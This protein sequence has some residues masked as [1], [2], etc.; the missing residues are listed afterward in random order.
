MATRKSLLQEM[1]SYIP[2]RGKEDVIQSRAD[3]ILTSAINLLEEIHLSFP[4]EEAIALE[5]RF[6][7]SV[8]NRD[9]RRFSRAMVKIKESKS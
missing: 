5:K 2:H 3:H 9:T 8:K 4:E 1:T 6:I 7:S